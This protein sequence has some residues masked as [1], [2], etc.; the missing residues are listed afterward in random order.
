MSVY[1]NFYNHMNAVTICSY[2]DPAALIVPP[3]SYQSK[4][5]PLSAS[6]FFTQRQRHIICTGSPS[7]KQQCEWGY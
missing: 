5:L 6:E 4:I 1:D 2:S 3:E 7:S